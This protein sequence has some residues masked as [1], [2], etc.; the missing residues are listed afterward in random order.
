MNLR[1]G[2]H[3]RV[4]PAPPSP[5]FVPSSVEFAPNPPKEPSQP[6]PIARRRMSPQERE[7]EDLQSSADLASQYDWATW[8]MYAR[9]TAARRLRAAASR[10]H[11]HAEPPVPPAVFE[12]D[13]H[14]PSEPPPYAGQDRPSSTV[15][16]LQDDD[17][18]FTFDLT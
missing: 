7:M 10:S 17:G 1:R 18:V 6:I 8:Q 16:D 3:A 14:H 11:G 5:R 12:Q 15:H 4:Q 2:K 13:L 9:I